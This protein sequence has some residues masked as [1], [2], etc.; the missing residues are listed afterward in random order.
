MPLNIRLILWL[1]FV[2]VGE[3]FYCTPQ[4]LGPW[5]T[6]FEM[7]SPLLLSVV[8]DVDVDVLVEIL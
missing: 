5:A 3:G 6:F 8:S 4:F 2:V 7:F 1:F